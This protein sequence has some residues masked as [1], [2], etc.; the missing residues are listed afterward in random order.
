MANPSKYQSTVNGGS[1]CRIRT[2][3]ICQVASPL[4]LRARFGGKVSAV[5]QL[6]PAQG[7][8][9]LKNYDVSFVFPWVGVC[10]GHCLRGFLGTVLKGLHPMT[11][12]TG[13]KQQRMLQLMCAAMGALENICVFHMRFEP[14]NVHVTSMFWCPGCGFGQPV[15]PRDIVFS[16]AVRRVSSPSQTL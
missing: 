5:W 6:H 2:S 1:R 16:I 4:R 14:W 13:I 8:A 10:L 12:G 9:H 3:L 15:L 11:P 7:N